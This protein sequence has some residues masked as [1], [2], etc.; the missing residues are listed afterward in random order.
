MTRRTFWLV[1]V[2]MLAVG[3]AVRINNVAVFPPLQ[4]YDGFSHF[5]YIWFMAEHWRVPLALT[6]WEFFQPPLYYAFM[7]SLWDGLAPMDPM[8]RLRIG[9]LVIAM[10]GL[11]LAA[12]SWLIVRREFPK[13][14]LVQLLA[15]GLMLFV[16]VH[17]Y[18]AGFLGNENLTAVVSA[19]A[20]LALLATLRRPTMPRAVILGLMLGL[21]MLTKFTGLVAVTGAFGTLGLRALVRRDW[22]RDGRVAVVAGVVMLAT[23]GWFYARN[24]EHYG[25]PFKMSRE[26]FLLQRY[27]H[28][29]TRGQRGILEYILFDPMILRRPEWPRG[30]GLVG[31]GAPGY[32]AMRES[33][34]TGLYANTWFEGYG[35]WVLPKVTQDEGTRRSGQLLLT[36]GLV[37]SLLMLIGIGCAVA[38]LR[39]EGW[40]D[41][42]V[43][44]LVTFGAM[45]VVVVQ[46]TR[47]VPVHAAVKATYLMPASVVFSFWLAL[48][49]EWLGARRRRWLHVATAFSALLAVASCVVFLQ[50]R[51]IGSWWLEQSQEGSL[52]RN[53]SGV[54]YYAGGDTA[55]AHE[56]FELAAED[57]HHLGWENLSVLALE[58]D[59]PLE[60]LHYLRKAASLQPSQSL[61]TFADQV[62]FNQLTSAEYLNTMAVIYHRLGW[63]S[64]AIAAAKGA[65]AADPTLPEAAYDLALLKI[66]SALSRPGARDARWRSANVAQSRRLLFSALV[67]DP[68]F[69]EAR[70]LSGFI[71]AVEGDCAG[72]IPM[73]ELALH[74][75]PATYR[76]YPV[77]TGVGDLLASAVRRRRYISDFPESMRPDLQLARCRNEQRTSGRGGDGG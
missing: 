39:R 36:L 58:A 4:A 37:P 6:G 16:P 3:A 73:L 24:V 60:A 67:I 40:N 19:W 56:L 54:V 25:T 21:A 49:A 66:T 48:G 2:L 35:G 59:R 76:S 72:A 63:D 15:P 7:A 41:T 11:S 27:E 52:W 10:L 57:N 14:R 70:A 65:V 31:E 26:M 28:I 51:L 77:D 5:S 68:G 43:A 17:L 22:R 46:G 62:L 8:L 42:L 71:A 12:V 61:G 47:A 55:R 20:L 30:V 1:A 74:P 18:T 33:V 64:A 38:R 23:C 53:V 29:Q 9:T 13:D 50:G 45:L 69:L 44:M 75:E 34:I 32:S